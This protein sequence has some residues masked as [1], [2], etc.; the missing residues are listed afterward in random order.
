[1]NN[2]CNVGRHVCLLNCLL[3]AIF[4]KAQD[5]NY[6]FVDLG[7]SVKWANKNVGATKVFDYGNYFAWAETMA[8]A[9]YDWTTYL[10]SDRGATRMIKYNI[11]TLGGVLDFK[12]ELEATDDAATVN[13]GGIGGCQLF[14]K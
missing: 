3:I 12:I 2:R 1:M 6:D 9:Q 4:C 11:S 7:L 13:M 8:K 10:Y 5:V 14:W